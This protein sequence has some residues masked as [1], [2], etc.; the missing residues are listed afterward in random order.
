MK[1][2]SRFI[3]KNIIQIFWILSIPL[4]IYS[5]F[6]ENFG[7]DPHFS[8]PYPWAGVGI[9]IIVTGIETALLYLIW[10]PNNFAW[11]LTRAL[12]AFVIFSFLYLL[13]LFA[14]I[15]DV[16][17]YISVFAL[18][19]SLLTFLSLI[20]FILTLIIKITQLFTNLVNKA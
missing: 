9:T 13:L 2:F 11:S 19:T 12:F 17:A 18:Y 10:R 5:G 4:T 3:W 16:P 6:R 1:Q 8:Q 7:L 15:A 14:P 20:L